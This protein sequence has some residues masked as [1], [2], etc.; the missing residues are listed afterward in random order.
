M[1]HLMVHYQLR[2][3]VTN[4]KATNLRLKKVDVKVN[5]NQE[6]LKILNSVEAILIPIALRFLYKTGIPIFNLAQAL[7]MTIKMS[8]WT[9]PKRK[10]LVKVEKRNQKT[11]I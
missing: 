10:K 3:K 8:N 9:Q 7:L 1:G 6:Y 11:L 5:N 4:L 2:R